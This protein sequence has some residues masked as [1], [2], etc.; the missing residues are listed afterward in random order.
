M[1]QNSAPLIHLRNWADE[2]FPLLEKLLGDPAMT[3]HLGGPETHEQLVNRQQRYLKLTDPLTA[4]TYGILLGSEAVGWVGYWETEHQGEPI[5]E[6]GWSVLPAFQGQSI[7]SQATLIALGNL[8]VVAQHRY[9]HAFPSVENLP[10]NGVCRKA[11]FTLIE[12]FDG[13][14]PKG[15]FMRCNDW[16]LDLSAQRV[17]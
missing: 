11:G 6:M 14:Y 1:T 17:M 3:E 12:A 10:S 13:E 9:V 7:A 16:R 8:R 4:Q 15:H 5:Y 2:D